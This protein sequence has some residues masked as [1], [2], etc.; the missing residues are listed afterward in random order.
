MEDIGRVRELIYSGRVGDQEEAK[1]YVKACFG[2]FLLV[3]RLVYSIN[4]IRTNQ[5]SR[6]LWRSRHFLLFEEKQILFLI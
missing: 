2:A 3:I 4:T 5:T 1:A 6:K